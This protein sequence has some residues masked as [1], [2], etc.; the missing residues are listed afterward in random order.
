MAETIAIDQQ[1]Q[2]YSEQIIAIV[3]ELEN[4]Y[5]KQTELYETFN[6]YRG[7]A[8]GEIDQYSQSLSKQLMILIEGYSILA[9]NLVEIIRV[10]L[11]QDTARAQQFFLG[12][13]NNMLT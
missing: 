9:N 2:T 8:K 5:M 13:Q 3:Y 12:I 6:Q 10:F 11:E 7:S 1:I 4:F